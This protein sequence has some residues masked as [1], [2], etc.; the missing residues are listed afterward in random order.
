MQL[1]ALSA[2]SKVKFTQILMAVWSW[3][4]SEQ[5]LSKFFFVASTQTTACRISAFPGRMPHL[6]MQENTDGQRQPEI[7]DMRWKKESRKEKEEELK[8]R[9]RKEKDK[10]DT[11]KTQERQ[12]SVLNFSPWKLIRFCIL[13]YDYI[14][15][16]YIGT[17][18]LQTQHG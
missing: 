3:C 4:F 14:S 11:V 10:A 6:G 7:R 1:F 9:E 13:Q 8:P 15:N 16:S 2:G 18:N 12:R 17:S 5:N